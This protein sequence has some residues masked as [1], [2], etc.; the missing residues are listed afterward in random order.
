MVR[1]TNNG[2][3]AFAGEAL[4]RYGRM[5]MVR[6]ANGY[7]SLYAHNRELLVKEGD[8]V[9]GGQA[10]AEVGKSGDVAEGQLRFELRK[11]MQ[12]IDPERVLAG[13]MIIL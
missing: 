10:I 12:P 7:L 13:T 1:A 4:Q 8:A 6:H 2:V 9:Y 5:I 3:V 11:R